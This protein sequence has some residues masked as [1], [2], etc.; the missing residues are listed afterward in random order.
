V[1]MS[2]SERHGSRSRAAAVKELQ[3]ES[4]L[5]TTADLVLLFVAN[6]LILRNP[7]ILETPQ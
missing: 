1:I 6:R 3:A 4:P 7:S 5:K 2:I